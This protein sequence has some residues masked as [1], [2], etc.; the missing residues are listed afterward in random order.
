MVHISQ[1]QSPNKI[2]AASPRFQ[3]IDQFRG[4]VGIL[5]L[6]GH[7]SYYF[8]AVWLNLDPLDPLFSSWGQFALRYVG[9]LCA[10]G[11]LMMSGAMV[12]WS[13]HRRVEKGTSGRKASWHL[14]QRGLFLIFLQITWVNSSWG[15]FSVFNPGHF[16]IIACI[17]C[18]VILLTLIVKLNWQWRLAI[19]LLILVVHPFLLQISY[20]PDNVFARVLMQTFIDAGTYNK[21][22]VLP[23]FALSVMGSVMATGWLKVWKSDK[24]RIVKGLLIALVALVVAIAI[25]MGRGYG[26]IFSFSNFGSYSFFLDQKYPPSLFMSLL[27]F[28]S[29]VFMVSLFI[30]I[31]KISPKIL[32]VFT[33]PGKV[34]LFFYGMHLAILGIFV[35]RMDFF[36]REGGIVAT[37]IGVAVM[38]V[39]M[40]PLCKWFY[41][42]KRKSNN[43]FIKLI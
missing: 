19:A 11:F 5:M 15:G 34:P 8:N 42:V 7:C 2:V 24:E 14:I 38:L 9:Y 4:F 18:S 29:V 12:W 6:V 1:D 20:N 40:L 32:M 25:R 43:Y 33:V 23:W 36:Y 22:P 27:S 28:S 39:I 13:F 16:G 37:F 17:G 30:A 21:Y 3:Y 10:P 41:G 31:G 26:N 35:K